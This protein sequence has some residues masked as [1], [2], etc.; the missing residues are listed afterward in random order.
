MIISFPRDAELDQRQLSI[1]QNDSFLRTSVGID[2][3]A[4]K[5]VTYE[6]NCPL[7]LE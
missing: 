3:S 5:S 7:Q 1:R 6:G 2:E 4:D